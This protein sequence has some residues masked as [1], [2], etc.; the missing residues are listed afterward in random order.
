[1]IERGYWRHTETGQ[2]WAVEIEDE[3]PVKCAGPL[4]DDDLAQE[5]LPH[6]DPRRPTSL[7]FKRNGSRTCRRNSATSA[8]LPCITE[9]RQHPTAA[10]HL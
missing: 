1:M 8:K 3:R 6:L 4:T 5:L 10:P 7:P 2:I 9:K